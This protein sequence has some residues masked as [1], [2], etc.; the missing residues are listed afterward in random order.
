MQN[1]QNLGLIFDKQKP[2]WTHK[3]AWVIYPWKI[4]LQHDHATQWKF[5]QL[6]NQ[7]NSENLRYERRIRDIGIER[8]RLLCQEDSK[9]ECWKTF[10]RSC[11]EKIW[12]VPAHM[13]L[14]HKSSYHS[15]YS[16]Q[17]MQLDLTP[18]F[19]LNLQTSQAIWTL[20]HYMHKV[21]MT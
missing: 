19:N 5:H 2:L 13:E 1:E 14:K 17:C 3:G 9:R 8:I 18:W 4:I 11:T 15:Q 16:W 6:F 20:C 7:C 21:Y 12:Q 10:I